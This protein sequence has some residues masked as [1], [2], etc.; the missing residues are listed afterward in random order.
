MQRD[1]ALIA[2]TSLR[3]TTAQNCID[4]WLPI[5]VG[6]QG[7]TQQESVRKQF[8]FHHNDKWLNW[9]TLLTFA[10][11]NMM[12]YINNQVQH[13]GPLPKNRK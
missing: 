13:I 6:L 11:L 3:R 8:D 2:S 9:F 4:I 10:T 5:M 12:I 7:E 1:T